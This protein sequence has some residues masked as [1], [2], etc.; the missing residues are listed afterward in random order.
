M[1]SREHVEPPLLVEAEHHSPFVSAPL[2]SHQMM[3][4]VLF[5]IH[6][7][8]IPA[9]SLLL[10]IRRSIDEPEQRSELI[11]REIA[12]V[13]VG[14]E[15]TVGN[16]VLTNHLLA[17]ANRLEEEAPAMGKSRHSQLGR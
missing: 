6:L 15:A 5:F 16:A 17:N 12:L 14:H 1:G 10:S 9:V 8:G 4:S 7:L 13:H 2:S 11:C 3:S